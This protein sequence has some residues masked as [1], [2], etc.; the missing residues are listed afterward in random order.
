M[1]EGAR[2]ESVYMGNCIEG[3]NPFLSAL[4]SEALAK[5]GYSFDF[6]KD[7]RA[8][9]WDGLENRCTGNCTQ[10]SNP[11]LS[12]SSSVALAEEDLSLTFIP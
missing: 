8:V 2:L 10:G 6:W 4:P 12:A 9:E 7:A 11:C 3:S 5:E 1:V